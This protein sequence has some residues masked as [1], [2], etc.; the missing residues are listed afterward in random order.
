MSDTPNT[1]TALVE[2]NSKEQRAFEGVVVS[3]THWDREWY[4]TF[5]QYRRRLVTVMDRLLDLLESKPAFKTFTFDGQACV[6]EDYLRIRP[7]SEERIRRLSEAGRLLFGPWF[8][9]PDEWLVSGEAMIRNLLMG[10]RV[11]SEFGPVNTAGYAPDAFGHCNQLP[12]ILA[13]FGITS[14]LFTR[15]FGDEWDRLGLTYRWQS[16]DPEI[17][18]LGVNLVGGYGNASAL[19]YASPHMDMPRCELSM[20]LAEERIR[21]ILDRLA[22]MARTCTLLFNN[23]VDH[24]EAQWNLPEV[25]DHINRADLGVQLRHGTYQDFV[26]AVLAEDAPLETYRGEFRL[27]RDQV[28]LHGILSTRINLKQAN[29]RCQSLLE[30]HAEPLTGL[31]QLLLGGEDLRAFLREA[32]RLVLLNHPHDDICGCSI[33]QVHREMVPRFDQAQQI[34]E[35]ISAE[36]LRRLASRHRSRR[37]EALGHVA[38]FNPSGWERQGSAELTVTLPTERAGPREPLR[39][40]RP[41][42]EIVPAEFKFLRERMAGAFADFDPVH[43]R[44]AVNEWHVRFATAP[45]PPL[46]IEPLAIERGECGGISGITAT[47]T[48]L[49]NE[50]LTARVNPNGTV[51]L[52]CRATGTVHRGLLMF[53]DVADVGDEYDF[54]PAD[55]PCDLTTADCQ[56][57]SRVVDRGPRSATLEVTVP[58]QLPARIDASR[59]RRVARRVDSTLTIRLTLRSKSPLLEAEI[60]W[61]N[62]AC[63]HRLRAIF[64][65]SIATD[66]AS[67]EAHFDVMDRPLEPPTP[68]VEWA[69]PPVNFHPMDRFVSLSDGERGLAVIGEGLHE[70]EASRDGDG[71][72]LEVTILRSVGWL[73]LSGLSTRI[74]GAAGPV[75]ET[76]DAQLLGPR[77]VRLAIASHRGDWHRGEVH[78]RAQEFNVPLLAT[79]IETPRGDG[80]PESSLVRSEPGDLMITACK[81]SERRDAL[82]VRVLNVGHRCVTGRITCGFDIAEAWLTDLA[83]DRQSRCEVIDDRAAAV[84]VRPR[85]LVTVE[86]TRAR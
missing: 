73:A 34:A 59:R 77:R 16:A 66:H 38:V 82:I 60:S 41:N 6:L 58:W 44:E 51:D 43:Q 69:Q 5:Q 64:P 2:G 68:R 71:T 22:P 65:T 14:A 54:C 32:W 49:E 76:P 33:D 42:G 70:Y 80:I 61:E 17:S 13:G 47:D 23:G 3:Q 18:V 45:L 78:R 12:Q 79:Q 53:E 39:L 20:G 86:F 40:V 67:A 56:A 52:E 50:H 25:I 26:D 46:G 15:G 7:E 30:G 29:A 48:L 19:G 57:T 72:R 84:T 28:I 8:T 27:G 83:E 11:A 31:A 4:A 85:Q 35:I 55:E 74:V 81:M 24:M 63:D 9:L 1:S 62:R 75:I 10:R 21:A 36:S 37:P